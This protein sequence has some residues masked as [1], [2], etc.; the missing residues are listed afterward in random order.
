[1]QGWFSI[2]QFDSIMHGWI[3]IPIRFWFQILIFIQ[4]SIPIQLW[5]DEHL[6]ILV[7]ILA[8]ELDF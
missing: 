4:V 5:F 3:S 6:K 7:D 2:S 8:K 1:M